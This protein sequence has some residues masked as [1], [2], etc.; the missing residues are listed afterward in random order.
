MIGIVDS[1]LGGL[2]T[3]FTLREKHPETSFIVL[4]DQKNAPYGDKTRDEIYEIAYR[5]IK[6]FKDRG[7]HEVIVACNTVCSTVLDELQKEFPDMKLYNIISATLEEL[8]KKRY[9]G[10]VVLATAATTRSMKYE[11]GLKGIFP[12][13]KVYPVAPKE[14]VP[15]IESGASSKEIEDLLKGYLADY[16]GKADAVLLGCTHYPLASKEIKK[17]LPVKQYDPNDAIE[18]T[19]AFHQDENPSLEVYTTG[20]PRLTSW[21]IFKLF[22]EDVEVKGI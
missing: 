16:Q 17:A 15:L 10:I 4:A 1:G 5:N 12:G 11:N 7:I 22:H 3:C 2:K 9:K 19:V 8:K 20:N 6:W 21:Q 18:K 13:R 14:L